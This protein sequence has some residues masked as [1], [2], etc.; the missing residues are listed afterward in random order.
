MRNQSG[1]SSLTVVNV[2]EVEDQTEAAVVEARLEIRFVVF[3]VVAL[4]M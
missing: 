4:I 1:E 3:A 2:G